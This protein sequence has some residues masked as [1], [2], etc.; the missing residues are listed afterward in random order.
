MKLELSPSFDIR[1]SESGHLEGHLTLT[2][3]GRAVTTKVGLDTVLYILD[4]WLSKAQFLGTFSFWK[5]SSL[6]SYP[7]QILMQT[8]NNEIRVSSLNC[9]SYLPV[10]SQGEKAN[11]ND[12]AV[13]WDWPPV[14][15]QSDSRIRTIAIRCSEN[16]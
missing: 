11:E 8:S 10:S 5:C 4:S 2:P 9:S 14:G 7:Y 3:E 1:S 13:S 16:F 15:R 12:L 6:V